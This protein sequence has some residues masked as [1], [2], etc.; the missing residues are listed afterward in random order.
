MKKPLSD[1]YLELIVKKHVKP[2]MWEE[3]SFGDVVYISTDNWNQM[4]IGNRGLQRYPSDDYMTKLK[5]HFV[6]KTLGKIEDVYENGS[7]DVKFNDKTFRLKVDWLTK[8]E[9]GKETIEEGFKAKEEHSEEDIILDYKTLYDMFRKEKILDIHEPTKHRS[10]SKEFGITHDTIVVLGR[11]SYYNQ[12]ESFK[13]PKITNHEY[14]NGVLRKLKRYIESLGLY[15]K[16]TD[17]KYGSGLGSVQ[18]VKPLEEGVGEEHTEEDALTMDN[19]KIG[20]RVRYIG[21]GSSFI[22][23]KIGTVVETDWGGDIIGVDYDDFKYGHRM[24]N[25]KIKRNILDSTSGYRVEIKELERA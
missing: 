13:S 16:F 9:G 5:P 24:W 17:N 4:W 8:L 21:T 15:I 3:I 18:T 6:N 7:A 22:K 10:L 14:D 25:N 23:N 1:R 12:E 20:D 11:A 2:V 19:I